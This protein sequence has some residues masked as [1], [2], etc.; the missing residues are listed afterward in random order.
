MNVK[1]LEIT[2]LSWALLVLIAG[3]SSG[4]AAPVEV[5]REA[6]QK[7]VEV[8][9]SKWRTGAMRNDDSLDTYFIKF[10]PPHSVPVGFFLTGRDSIITQEDSVKAFGRRLPVPVLIVP[11]L[12]A[13]MSALDN[14]ISYDDALNQL[15]NFPSGNIQELVTQ[16]IRSARNPAIK[17]NA[18]LS[19]RRV[20]LNRTTTRRL[21]DQLKNSNSDLV[22]SALFALQPYALGKDLSG[23]DDFGFGA[24]T[25]IVAQSLRLRQNSY[26]AEY[27]LEAIR[28]SGF[29]ARAASLL[30]GVLSAPQFIDSKKS[31]SVA[32]K[33]KNLRSPIDGENILMDYYIKKIVGNSR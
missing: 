27:V 5:E 15:A 3:P 12:K 30:L 7:L 18:M 22:L 24:P 33:L 19:L 21:A 25:P 17:V 20:K 13:I 2:V 32:N 14:E 9:E 23:E 11:S 6:F 8:A 28:S 29:E 31:V 1:F 10:I 26:D 16:T 4:T